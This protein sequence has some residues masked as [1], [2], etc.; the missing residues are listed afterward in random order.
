MKDSGHDRKTV[1]RKV[2]E[3][4][5]S[6]GLLGREGVETTR[7]EEGEVSLQATKLRS[8]GI[9]LRNSTNILF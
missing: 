2:K 7:L 4:Y 6:P 1:K 9:T 3:H 8:L 5:C